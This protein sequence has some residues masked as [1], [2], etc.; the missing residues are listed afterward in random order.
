MKLNTRIL[1]LGVITTG[2]SQFPVAAQNFT[3]TFASYPTG[4]FPSSGGWQLVYDG[5][6]SGSQVVVNAPQRSGHALELVGSSCWDSLAFHPLTLPNKFT[7]EA[8]L[9]VSGDLSGG[10]NVYDVQ[11]GCDNPSVGQWGTYYGVV[12]FQ[13]DG[14]IHVDYGTGANSILMPYQKNTW[15]HVA[16]D[17]DLTNKTM[18][19]RING[20]ATLAQDPITSSGTPT[21]IYV[22]AG[23]GNSPTLWIANLSVNAAAA[24]AWTQQP[25]SDVVN[26]G[27]GFTFTSQATGYPEPTYQW[28]FSTNG[29][30][31][32]NLGG[33]T[34]A[35]YSLASSDLTNIGFYR[36]LAANSVN[37]NTSATVSLT[38][39]N[40]N[41]Y[42]GLNILGPVGA[43]YN[44]QS[45]P[46]LNGS[47]WTTLTNVSL[48][49]Q[50]YIYIDYNSPTNAKQFYR[51]VPQ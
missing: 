31:F 6:G 48:A 46:A 7:Y 28:Q 14:N 38:F 15:Y 16:C 3:E 24:P 41:M 4:A 1:L 19:I 40:L 39:L 30:T 35:S 49:S 22:D 44:V 18:G 27:Q 8:D 42:A 17:Y 10:C 29:S 50:P 11:F 26:T 37:T 21:G 9:L 51:A 12:T 32:V 5:A 25:S 2:L 45:T 34:G 20:S 36:V 43:N 23:H 13:S 33:A 47:N